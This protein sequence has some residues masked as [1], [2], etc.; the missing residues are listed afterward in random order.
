LIDF[1]LF[2]PRER[3]YLY[4]PLT[5]LT[6]DTNAEGGMYTDESGVMIVPVE[7]QI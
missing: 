4:A 3:Y 1:L 5:F 6:F 2:Y 7:P